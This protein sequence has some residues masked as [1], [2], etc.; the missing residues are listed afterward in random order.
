MKKKQINRYRQSF[1]LIEIVVVIV[2]LVTLMSIAT[3][4]YMNYVKKANVGAAK[5]QVQMLVQALDSSRL[6]VGSYPES[7]VG[8]Q[9]LVE[10]P[11]DN[12]KWGGP[13]IKNV[14]KDPWGNEYVYVSPG[15]HGD[16]D[17]YS[18]GS[19]G[20]V[21]GTGD[22]ADITTWVEESDSSR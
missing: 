13:Y 2:I 22:A 10:N 17:L 4:L 6:D 20:Q 1:T 15:E 3:P 16:F 7:D 12:E 21:G 11:D 5:T 18:M 14:P 8:L 9:A 19:D